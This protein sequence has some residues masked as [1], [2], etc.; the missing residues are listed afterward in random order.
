MASTTTTTTTTPSSSAGA[1]AT[2][3][4]PLTGSCLCGNITYTIA[5]GVAPVANVICYCENCTKQ[6]GTHMQNSSIFPASALRITS[7][8]A[9]RV[10]ADTKVASGNVLSRHFCDRC[11]S[12]IYGVSSR[13]EGRGFVSIAVGT[14]DRAAVRAAGW[15]WTPDMVYWGEAKPAWL[16]AIRVAEKERPEGW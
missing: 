8:A 1:A 4:P 3:S 7:P 12:P 10:Y 15:E 11:G 9:P 6:T 16:D 5:G 13:P 2:Q 14:L